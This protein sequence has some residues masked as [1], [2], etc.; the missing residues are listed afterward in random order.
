ML[1]AFVLTLAAATLSNAA[2]VS[3]STLPTVEITV[4]DRGDWPNVLNTTI[5][6]T[7]GTL[8]TD[9]ALDR[10]SDL[11]L[12]SVEVVPLET[13]TCTPYLYTDGTGRGGL[14]FLEDSPS[15]LSTNTVQVGSI[16]CSTS[17]L[18]YAA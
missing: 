18:S 6:G 14:P 11:H 8:I 9:P 2:P 12:S 13:V 15:F 17:Q 7:L 16:Y 10:V 4:V 5:C 1:K 3:G